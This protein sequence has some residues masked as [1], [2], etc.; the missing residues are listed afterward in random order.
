VHNIVSETKITN[1]DD[2][3]DFLLTLVIPCFNEEDT[4]IHSYKVM[5]EELVSI[6]N[7][8]Y[9]FIDDGSSDTTWDIIKNLSKDNADVRGI[10]LSRNFGHQSAVT[11]GL[12]HANG[13]CIV[14][15][16]ADLQDPP[17]IIL[18]MLKLWKQGYYVVF[19]KRNKRD[20]ESIFKIL[21]ANI[22]YRFLNYLSGNFIP[23]DTGDFRLIDKEINELLKSMPEYDRYLRGMIAW[24]GY[25]QI[26]IEYNRDKR[27]FGETKY[28]LKKMIELASSA[29]LSFSLKPLRLAI[30]IGTFS[31]FLAGAVLV[32]ALIIKFYG[33]VVPGWTT[34]TVLISFFSGIQL[35]CIGLL[36]EYVG[37]AF[38][39]SKS[40]PTF[41][42]EKQT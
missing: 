8:E 10:K 42:I 2:S 35:I 26:G 22:F 19:G 32:Y 23:K 16:D 14:I 4:L 11:A 6:K 9:I 34:L 24:V 29:V 15:I 20:G 31:A 25:P 40:R 18:K 7:I 30:A 37:R 21:T 33:S 13:D 1:I 28:T 27:N 5:T 38:I 39:Q 12:S 3:S 36:G 41:I 17:R